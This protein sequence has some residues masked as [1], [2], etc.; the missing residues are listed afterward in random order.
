MT[1]TGKITAILI[2]VSFIVLYVRDFEGL[3]GSAKVTLGLSVA[4]LANISLYIVN[5]AKGRSSWLISI[6]WIYAVSLYYAGAFFFNMGSDS[7]D[8][9]SEIS[10]GITL[11][12]IAVIIWLWT[13]KN[14]DKS[15]YA[16]LFWDFHPI[17]VGLLSINLLLV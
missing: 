12:I 14:A 3:E 15:K 13:R 16:R 9:I 6:F 10:A 2:A 11:L 4:Y 1:K 7:M 5:A 17:Y 8:L